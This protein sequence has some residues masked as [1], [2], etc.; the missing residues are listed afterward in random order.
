VL[1]LQNFLLL[2]LPLSRTKLQEDRLL[3]LEQI[4]MLVTTKDYSNQ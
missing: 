4:D 3:T 1:D 2:I